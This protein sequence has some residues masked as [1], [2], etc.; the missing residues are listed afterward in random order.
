M[1]SELALVT[2]K[3]RAATVYAVVKT[4]VAGKKYYR[5]GPSCSKHVS[6]TSLLRGQLVKCFRLYNQI[7][8]NFFCEEMR[9][10]ITIFCNAKASRF[11][12]TKNIGILRY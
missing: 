10:A 6:L 3:P 12:P 8:W 1:L 11:F 2:H 9:E 4:R 7:H 5:P